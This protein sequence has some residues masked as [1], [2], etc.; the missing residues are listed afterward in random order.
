MTRSWI[1]RVVGSAVLAVTAVVALPAGAAPAATAVKATIA[2]PHGFA[3]LD[4]VNAAGSVWSLVVDS[5]RGYLYRIDPRTSRITAELDL[6]SGPPTGNE[7]Y[8]GGLV[9]AYGSL[10]VAET[11]RDEVLRIDPVTRRIVRRI[12]T[13][14][15]PAFL[16]AGAARSGWPSTRTA[17]SPGS[18]RR[19]TP[20][21]RPSRSAGRTQPAAISRTT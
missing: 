8:E 19:G 4:E 13:G 21:S 17:A 11:F 10:W 2:L 3:A 15:Y 9:A 7:A 16:A 1:G 12:P 18:T 14:R 5:E 20:S 6:P